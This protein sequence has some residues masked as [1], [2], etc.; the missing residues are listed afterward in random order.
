M[1]NIF[2]ELKKEEKENNLE[3]LLKKNEKNF[4]F[5]EINLSF[6]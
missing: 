5:F 6:Y 2:K 1:K 3:Y 4:I